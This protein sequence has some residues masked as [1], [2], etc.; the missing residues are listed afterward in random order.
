MFPKL[1]EGLYLYQFAPW[2][3]YA[4]CVDHVPDGHRGSRGSR[5]RARA[6]PKV[7]GMA[8]GGTVGNDGD[9][10]FGSGDA[11]GLAEVRAEERSMGW[12]RQF[13]IRRF[14]GGEGRGLRRRGALP[15]WIAEFGLLIGKFDPIGMDE[16][17]LRPRIFGSN[18]CWANSKKPRP[19]P[20]LSIWAAVKRGE[21]QTTSRRAC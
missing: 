12:R 9:A 6:K 10:S 8:F 4:T 19:R 13:W 11:L 3:A 14:G 17:K 15:L 2:D 20:V 5:V 18:L 21:R 7:V 16:A 1:G